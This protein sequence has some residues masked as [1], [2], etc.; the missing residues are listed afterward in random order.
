M[1]DLKKYGEFQ[2]VEKDLV[3]IP[4]FLDSL[5]SNHY[6]SFDY[7]GDMNMPLQDYFLDRT[8]S[9]AKRYC[10]H[11]QYIVT[12]QYK[13]N[14]YWNFMEWFDKFN[15]LEISSEILGLGN[16]CRFR[17]LNQYLKHALDYAFKHTRHQ[18][19]HIYGL[20]MLAIPYANKRA[21]QFNIDLSV[22]STKWTRCINDVCR[23]S[24]SGYASCRKIN[25]QLFFDEYLKEIRK[26]GVKLDNA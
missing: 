21:R 11:P 23:E 19:M 12:V 1:Y 4:D 2:W 15:N 9:N 17:T 26:R 3:H 13:H 20:C 7:P 10:K 18:R 6:F 22:D 5:P 8:W 24:N 16:L 14:N 25:R